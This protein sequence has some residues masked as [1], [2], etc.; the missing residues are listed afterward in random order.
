MTCQI[1]VVPCGSFRTVLLDVNGPLIITPALLPRLQ[2]SLLQTQIHLH[3]VCFINYTSKHQL[4]NHIWKSFVY[5]RRTTDI[6]STHNVS[7]KITHSSRIRCTAINQ[8]F[9]WAK[10]QI[11]DFLFLKSC[12]P[13]NIPVHAVNESGIVNFQFS[14]PQRCHFVL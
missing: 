6:I 9:I 4:I 13:L 11:Q 1:E 8:M 12:L 14:T 2:D 7:Q 10:K 5:G 3:S